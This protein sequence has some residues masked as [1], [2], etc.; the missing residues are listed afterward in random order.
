M[1]KVMFA[2]LLA[3]GFAL[4]SCGGGA[5][6]AADAEKLCDC[7]SAA[8]ENPEKAEE[9]SKLSEEFMA[10]YKDDIQATTTFAEVTSKCL[11]DAVAQ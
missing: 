9:C 1:K 3:G 7:M 6:P 11:Q 10:K 4:T 5:D 8:A 2:A